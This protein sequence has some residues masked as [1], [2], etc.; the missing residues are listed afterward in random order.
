MSDVLKNRVRESGHTL[1]KE[2]CKAVSEFKIDVED[3]NL[4][5]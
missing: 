5:L 4:I 2:M 3:L 1:E